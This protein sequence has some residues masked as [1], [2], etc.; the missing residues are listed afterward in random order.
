MHALEH[1]RPCIT[2]SSTDLELLA[3][4]QDLSGGTIINKKNY[5]PK[6]HK[7]SY[8]LN[9]KQKT[10]VFNLLLK[11]SQLLRVHQKKK[12][13]EFILNNYNQVT[14]RNGKYSR[15]ELEKKKKFEEDFFDL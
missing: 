1:R 6:K 3:Y 14:K 5:N 9:I 4:I 7:D 11:I 15:L 8:T 13:A 10:Q 12:R 2:I